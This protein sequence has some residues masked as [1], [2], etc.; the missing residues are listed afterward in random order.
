MYNIILAIVAAILWGASIPAL[1]VFVGE[2]N[3]VMM[4][5]LLY[6]GSGI[7]LGLLLVARQ[8]I[9]NFKNGVHKEAQLERSDLVWVISS[10]LSG[11]IAAPICLMQGL[12]LTPATVSSLFLNFEGVMT[13]VLG[14]LLFG[15]Y[16]GNRIW[17]VMILLFGGGLL[18]S[19]TSGEFITWNV[20]GPLLLIAA[21]AL[22]G[23]D[24]NLTRNIS[25]K[26]PVVLTCCKGLLGG[27]ATTSI[28]IF[29]KA[30]IPK[31][32]S[33]FIVL[34]IGAVC[35]G[36][37]LILFIY[38]L[39]SLGAARTSACFGTFPFLGAVLSVIFLHEELT[40]PI[41]SAFVIMGIAV[42]LLFSEQHFHLHTHEKI[43]H[44]H[45]HATDEHHMHLHNGTEGA[46]PHSHL[47]IHE[48][49]THEHHH[50]PDIH[51]RH[52]H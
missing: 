25:G 15:E 52:S 20:A 7:S 27:I 47:H 26:D 8:F 44:S 45:L 23:L 50:L 1:K 4:A 35:S 13:I 12:S 18:L 29:N 2:I 32:S 43:S 42:A 16:I 5:G 31:V 38:A 24:N 14:G 33:I 51:H 3:P 11:S 41:V 28:A 9:G 19:I 36:L 34:S 17:L 30:L 37:S 39:R 40:A 22:W 46:E 21:C 10:I 49:L 6:L 48:N